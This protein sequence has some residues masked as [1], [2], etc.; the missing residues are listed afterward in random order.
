MRV[1]VLIIIAICLSDIVLADII[2]NEIMYNQ[3]GKDN[4]KVFVEI[5]S[6]DYIDLS[7]FIIADSASNDSLVELKYFD[8]GYSLIV[9]EGFGYSNINAS[10][11][12]AG[13]TI[14]NNLNN[15]G[16]SITLFY[17]NGTIIDS[18]NYSDN[19]GA[20]G[21]D[22][23]LE[24]NGDNFIESLVIG[25]TPGIQNS[26]YAT[27][28]DEGTEE[29]PS[30]QTPE[31][32]ETVDINVTNETATNETVEINETAVNDTN[33]S[34]VIETIPSGGG[35]GGGGGGSKKIKPDFSKL[36]I[37]EFLP[38]PEGYDDAGMPGG[39]WIELYNPLDIEMDLRDMF[40]KDA[41]N[42]KLQITDTTVQA[43]TTIPANGYLVVYT[44]GKLGFL[45]NNKDSLL[46]YDKNEILIDDVSYA[47]SIE[48][49]S[50]ALIDGFWQS[51]MPT[52]GEEN[53][54]SSAFSESK[55]SIEKI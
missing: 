42:H 14:G 43:S 55:F 2:I 20:D 33:E 10:V 11:Y 8:S 51:T 5:Y 35:S 12:S 53:V 27:E 41:A 28:E 24:W 52:P 38:D 16:D 25:G 29:V 15:D 18:I 22:Y 1:F 49:N 45:N 31:N 4:N 21:N 17:S 23:T 7:G 19:L 44:N 37:S 26:V 39:E 32:N 34:T 30:N 13:A 3:E 50:Y 6:E 9:E 46:F 47:D 54:N 48:G 36:E 40:F